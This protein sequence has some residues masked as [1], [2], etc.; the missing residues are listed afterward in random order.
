MSQTV[1]Y[2]KLPEAEQQALNDALNWL[3]MSQIEALK[4]AIRMGV[5]FQQFSF[6]CSFA[7]FSGYPV[8]VLY[9]H[10]MAT[11]ELNAK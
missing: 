9:K 1:D 5:N 4:E 6:L 3:T 11:K 10:L 8:T 7:G 2:S